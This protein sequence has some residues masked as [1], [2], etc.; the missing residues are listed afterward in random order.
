[1]I[2][3]RGSEAKLTAMP[4]RTHDR[5]LQRNLGRDVVAG[6]TGF[7]PVRAGSNERLAMN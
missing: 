5:R 4:A 3:A 1:M 6:E 2:A 7:T